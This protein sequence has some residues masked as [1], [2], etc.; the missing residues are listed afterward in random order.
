MSRADLNAEG[1]THDRMLQDPSLRALI[2]CRCQSAREARGA[3]GHEPES[4]LQRVPREPPC[5][6]AVDVDMSDRK[7]QRER[8]SDLESCRETMITNDQRVAM[9]PLPLARIKS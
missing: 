9:R 2:R 6:D 1:E 3:G 4:S 7:E 8:G 5:D